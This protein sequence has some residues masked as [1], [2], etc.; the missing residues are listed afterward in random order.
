MPRRSNAAAC[1]MRLADTAPANVG[2]GGR[3]WPT[4]APVAGSSTRTS[5]DVTWTS[6]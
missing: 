2:V 4:R 1:A 3:Q 5:W 6:Q